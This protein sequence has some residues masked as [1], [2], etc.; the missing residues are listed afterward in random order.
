LIDPLNEKLIT[1]NE[2]TRHYPPNSKGRY[3]HVARVYPD[4]L[5]GK[6]GVRLE[7][8]RTPRLVTSREAIA[9]F[10]RRLSDGASQESPVLT[11][12][13]R[14]RDEERIERELDRIGI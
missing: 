6:N 3:V 12:Q 4:M 1:P 10:F 8:L 13:D 7:S 9:R 14:S 11:R 2:A 5:V